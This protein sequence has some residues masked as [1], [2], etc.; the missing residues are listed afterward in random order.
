MVDR[1]CNHLPHG[2]RIRQP[3]ECADRKSYSAAAGGAAARI[4]A[5]RWVD[6]LPV[7]CEHGIGHSPAEIARPEDVAAA[8]RVLAATLVAFAAIA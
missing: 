3:G 2:T 1:H 7:P 6:P 5:R 4:S 8:T